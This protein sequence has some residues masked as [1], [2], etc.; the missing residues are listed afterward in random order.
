MAI[1]NGTNRR[2]N[3]GR[4]PLFYIA[5]GFYGG[6][7]GGG[8]QHISMCIYMCAVENSV[9]FFVHRTVAVIVI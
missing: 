9:L 5:R 3:N 2:I 6:E 8:G 7:G 1:P 4:R